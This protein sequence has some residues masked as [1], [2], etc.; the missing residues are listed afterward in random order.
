MWFGLYK[1]E[2]FSFFNNYSAY[3][4]VVIY[5][6]LSLLTSFYFGL[7]YSI[8][9]PSMNSF[10]SFQPQI[11]AVIIPAIT[12]R[13]WSDEYRS[14]TVETL[15]TF[16]ISTA[17]L[18]TAKFFACF[19]FSALLVLST[20]PL[21]ITTAAVAE[22]DYLNIFSS[23]IGLFLSLGVFCA[24]GCTVSAFSSLPAVSY[25]FSVLASWAI[26]GFNFNLLTNQLSKV[27]PNAPFYFENSL[28]FSTH[29]QS[30]LNGQIGVDTVIYF[31]S[32][33]GFM[34]IFNS[35]VVSQRRGR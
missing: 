3:F 24:I 4:I 26:T 7:Y 28:N 9:N 16:P 18:V 5:L 12:M 32:F 20:L 29:Y 21:L 6:L 23:Y 30:F 31:I 1:R 13:A 35:V 10:F 22:L 8:D 15:L 33:A 19:T 14:G 2:F 25:L 11:L 17:S 27:L 34:L